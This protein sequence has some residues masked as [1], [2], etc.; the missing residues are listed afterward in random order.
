MKNVV[1]AV[2]LCSLVAIAS[3]AGCGVRAEV[4]KEKVIQRIDSM[5]GSMDVKRKEIEHSVIALKDG[6]SELRKAKIKA[7]VKDD[8]VGRKVADVED[9]IRRSDS[10]LRTLR[11]HLT[12]GSS[13][14]LAGTTYT[15]AK[16]NQL[17]KRVIRQRQ[18]YAAQ[19]AGFTKA[20][21]RLQKVV[22]TLEAKQTDYESKLADIEHQLAVI[23]SNRLALNAMKD[24][25]E[26][27]DG[28][29]K[30]LSQNV[31]Q[32][33]EKVNDLY[34]DVEAEL[35]GEDAEW[36]HRAGSRSLTSADA[37]VEAMQ[38]ADDTIGE[39]DAILAESYLADTSK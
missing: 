33:E 21:S 6:L 14:E 9:N 10:S 23:D 1:V 28:S 2:L 38:T 18:D 37:I 34:A 31:A 32:L 12:V 15:A 39:I 11:E 27:M 16:L 25:A 7:Q 36:Q 20:Q 35:I 5:L 4:A 19:L 17:S 30:S 29:E 8:Q 22:E 26:A 3:L 13:V 24:A